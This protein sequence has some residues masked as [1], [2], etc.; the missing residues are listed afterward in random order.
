MALAWER[1]WL[2]LWPAVALV[3]L[4]AVIAL[5]DLL[6]ALPAWLHALLLAGFA[7]GIGWSVWRARALFSLPALDAGRRRLELASGMQHRPLFALRDQLAGGAD[8]PIARSLWEAHRARVRAALKSVRV[9]W[10]SPGL[11]AKDPLALR[12]AL[13]LLL[14]VGVSI[15]GSDIGGRFARA[16]VPGSGAPPVPPGALDLWITPPAYT[17]LPPL[18]P[19]A[20]ATEPAQGPK[21]DGEPAAPQVVAAPAGSALL[22]QVTG[23]SG[24]PHLILDKH[25]TEFKPI[26]G[27]ESNES[28]PTW[29]VGTTLNAGSELTIKQGRT[30]LGAWPLKIVVDQPPTIEFAKKPS[31]SQRAAL[32]LEYKAHDDYG[33][34]SVNATIKRQGTV[35][36]G[37]PGQPIAV[38]LTLPGQNAKD[39]T[40]STYQDLTAHPW[41]GL[42]VT[43]QLHA[44]DAAGQTGDSAEVSMT[45]P[46][47]AFQNPVARAIIAE[48]KVLVADPEQRALVSDALS[49]IAGVP[50]QYNDDSVVFLALTT[51][52]AR[53]GRDQ[54]PEGAEAVQALLWD[55]ALRVEDGNLSVSERDLRALQQKLQDAL[56]RNAPDQEI[57]KLM[58][59][60]QQAIDRYLQAMM[61]NARQ[62]PDQMQP[63]NPNTRQLN[64]LDLQKLLDRARELA[65]TGARDAARN[66]LSQLQDLLEN[67]RAGRPMMGQQQGQGQGQQMMSQLQQLMQKQ[68]N[69]LD[70][71]FRRSQQGRPGMPGMPGMQQMMPGQRGQQG[72]Q[73]M[74]GQEG[75]D[76][77]EGDASGEGSGEQEALRRQ[78]GEMMRQLGEKMGNIPDALGRAERSMRDSGQALQEGAPGRALRPQMNALDQ[79]RAA[80]RDL[81]QQMAEQNGQ[82]EGEADQ[83]GDNAPNQ[84]NRDPAG[85]PLNG[86]GGLDGRDVNIPEASEIQ[87]SREILDELLR[88][89]GERFRPQIERDYIDRL[90][91]RF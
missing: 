11:P 1:L 39:A 46:E 77:Q 31:A 14:I 60:L 24:T 35:P 13:I 76:Q 75:D 45:L 81:A 67:L 70:K 57:E 89:A 55:T 71:T 78:L 54:T 3:G 61:E 15:A 28:A 52:A 7:A 2:A 47:R 20:A 58:Q 30:T 17:G 62:H 37:A 29:R 6:P 91:K 66:L 43:I 59:Q 87:R 44:T 53:L 22:A 73:G 88:R 84:A 9:G 10:P 72:Q 68:Q 27:R 32:R 8:D 4:F 21:G 86:L 33:L 90:L 16:L 82:G 49:A 65:R 36:A 63:M 80:A 69:L 25:D 40:G 38:P 19:H 56:A 18:L 83:F 42:P 34:A 64:S 26:E 12:A 74:Q 41:A 5:F 23:G 51:A 79:L 85:R 50:K 48:R